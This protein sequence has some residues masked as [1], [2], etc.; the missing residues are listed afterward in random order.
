MRPFAAVLLLFAVHAG[1][2]SIDLPPAT[3][4]A[5]FRIEKDEKRIWLEAWKETD[6]IDRSGML[7][8]DTALEDYLNGI[9]RRLQPPEVYRNI[10]FTIRILKNPYLNAF[11]FP[12][13]VIYVHSGLLAAME[14]EA[15]F[16]VLIAH[17]MTHATN[18]DAVRELR[19]EKNRMAI[20][21]MLRT[22][23]GGH[24]GE[25]SALASIA[26][27][28]RELES[29]ADEKGLEL[30]VKAGY[31]PRD[32]VRL[33]DHLRDEVQESGTSEPYFYGTHPRIQDRIDDFSRLLATRYANISGGI[34]NT[35]VFFR[36]IAA[37]VLDNAE[38]D[39]KAGR[40]ARAK[41]SLARYLLHCPPREGRPHYLMGEL[42]RQ[43]NH[44]GDRERARL[45]YD[46]AIAADPALAPAYR[47]MGLVLIRRSEPA[48]ARE[49]LQ[50]YLSRAPQAA[51]RE[52]IEGYLK[53]PAP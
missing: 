52:Y 15:Q 9:A 12:N 25:L 22:V 53:E 48:A 27:Y 10:P 45:E 51:D 35:E 5:E 38:L 16:A 50:A 41:R 47:G 30:V 1:C 8:E 26:G 21:A 13:G 14:S 29:E 33:F 40:Y 32:A 17:E 11:A 20:A 36:H 18:R 19:H 49:F 4:V 37:L 3:D 39:I 44:P 42:Y 24:R 7:Y 2:A 34:T 23:L 6:E 31:D 28:S 46:A 43:Q